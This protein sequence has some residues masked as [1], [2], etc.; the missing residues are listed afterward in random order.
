MIDG[1][2]IALLPSALRRRTVLGPAAFVLLTVGLVVVVGVP[3]Q[4][5]VLAVWLLLGLL[6]CSLSDVRGYVRGVVVDWLPFIAIL[7]AYDSL[8]GTAGHLSAVHYLP[9]LQI[10]RWLFGAAPTATLQHWLWHGHVVW[11]DVIFWVTYLTHFF[12][13]PLLAAVLWKIDRER[14]RRFAVLVA[15]LSFAGLVTYALFP[16]APPWMASQAGLM[17]HVTRIIPLV[18]GSV[19]LHSAGSLVEG[20]YH[21]ANNVAA[22]PSLHAAFSLLIA[23]TLWPRRRTWLRPLVAAYPLLMGFSLVFGAEHYVFDIL[24]GWG[25]T[26]GVLIAMRYAM[27]RW[28]ARR[29]QPRLAP[30]AVT[31]SALPEVS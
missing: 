17:G 31:G 8:R 22:V 6:C 7:I 24:L 23:V 29:A 14:F 16:A 28:E 4:R 9:Q 1:S 10:D 26:V 13:T 5:D 2:M 30:A 12:A 11:Y 20:G 19:G 15:G 3:Y 25:Y 21:Y 18:W 27:R